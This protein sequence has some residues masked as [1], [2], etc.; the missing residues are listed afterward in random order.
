M[1]SRFE[2]EAQRRHQRA[3]SHLERARRRRNGAQGFWRGLSHPER[4]A[5]HAQRVVD[6]EARLR[7]PVAIASLAIGL[8][9]GAGAWLQV[10][11]AFRDAPV[12]VERIGVRGAQYLDAG[13]VARATGIAPGTALSALDTEAL[14]LR[15]AEHDWI[16]SARALRLPDGTLVVE[17]EERQPIAIVRAGEPPRLFAVDASGTPFAPLDPAD[18][19][20]PRLH[21]RGKVEA[22]VACPRLAEAVA[23][24]ARLPDF[25][26]AAPAEIGVPAETSAGTSAEE[27]DALGFTLRF[28]ALPTRFVLGGGALE[29]SIERL[30]EAIGRHPGEVVRAA[31]VDLRFQDQAVL[32]PLSARK[33]SGA[34]ATRGSA[35]PSRQRRS[36]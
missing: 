32:S 4:S 33:G 34:A 29:A 28:A 9:L 18:A 8:V 15:L 16:A 36:G 23:L 1:S 21:T 10:G 6:A 24:V 27:G 30:V 19:L 3:H 14:S 26:L 2:R 25:G 11:D 22:R 12:T 5:W 31:R 13:E 35:A 20:L 17:V 7:I